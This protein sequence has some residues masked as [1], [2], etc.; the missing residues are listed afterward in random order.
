MLQDVLPGIPVE[1]PP[2]MTVLTKATEYIK[3]TQLKTDVDEQEVR[4]SARM[5][6]RRCARRLCR[7]DCC[8]PPL[9]C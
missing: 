3:R 5:A 7:R 2:R 1:N 9:P 8:G 4:C 6:A